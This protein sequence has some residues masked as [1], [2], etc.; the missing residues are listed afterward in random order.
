VARWPVTV[1]GLL[2]GVPYGADAQA[3]LVD[4]QVLV[5]T[6]RHLEAVGNP[7]AKRLPFDGPLTGLL[8][9]IGG[10][11]DAGER[12]CILASGDPGF[13]GIVRALAARFGSDA[14]EVHPAPSSVALAFARLGVPWDDAAVVSA[15]GRDLADAA[16]LVAHHRKVAVLVSPESPPEALAKALLEAGVAG[17]HVAVCSNLAAADEVVVR[18]DL[19]GLAAGTW[20]PLSVVVVWSGPLVPE[21]AGLSWGLPEER[22]AH[23]AGM[24]TKAEVRAIALGKLDLPSVG[25]L[26]DV[27][28]GSGSVAV[29]C[30]RLAPDLRVV[31]IE[32]NERDAE[33][34][35]ANAAAHRVDIEVVTG[36]APQ[37]FAALPPPDR[38]F[39]GGGGLDVLDA[40]LATLRPH[41]TI[42]ATYAALDRAAAAWG[43]LG[44]LVQVAVSRGEEVGSER[45]L[46]L[47][48]E[49]PVFVCWGPS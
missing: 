10:H 29:E 9:V 38:I 39:V 44:S 19:H 33:R 2:G 4:A 31:A 16:A 24:I 27:G 45:A 25:V 1:V 12:V 23:R 43:R 7:E 14:I 49:N 22:F 34:I 36:T 47:A 35:R 6:R 17:R 21:R 48:A 28:A 20:D 13:F 15:H 30:A 32:R 3:A 40:A 37:V 18:T 11:V 42:V 46:R 5:G 41:G 26:W 8:E